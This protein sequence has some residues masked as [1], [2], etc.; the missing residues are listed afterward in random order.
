MRLH[1]ALLLLAVAGAAH[2]DPLAGGDPAAGKKAFDEANCNGCHVKMTGGEPGRLFT[3]PERRVR[4]AQSLLKLVRFCISRTGASVF[5]ED[6]V[7]IASY[8]NRAYYKFE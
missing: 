8:L 3:R 4:D 2:A 1:T 5:P 6:E 7:N